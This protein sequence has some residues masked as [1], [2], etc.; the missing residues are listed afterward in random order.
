MTQYEKF[1]ILVNVRDKR[2]KLTYTI[3][4]RKLNIMQDQT[5]GFEFYWLTNLTESLI[6]QVQD[7]YY[8]LQI[9]FI[10]GS[11]SLISWRTNQVLLNN[12]PCEDYQ[13]ATLALNVLLSYTS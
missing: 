1:V 13:E 2:L 9:A 5:K 11:W 7:N 12:I 8:H 10:G 6:K 3:A 4:P